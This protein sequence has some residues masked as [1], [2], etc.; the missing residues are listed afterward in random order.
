MSMAHVYYYSIL[1]LGI[2]VD[3]TRLPVAVMLHAESC[4]ARSQPAV[5]AERARGAGSWYAYARLSGAAGTT[6]VD[7]HYCVLLVLAVKRLYRQAPAAV[8]VLR[9]RL[10]M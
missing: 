7:N 3:N 5:Q 9:G 8:H 4:R 1:Q 6:G 2:G 10:K